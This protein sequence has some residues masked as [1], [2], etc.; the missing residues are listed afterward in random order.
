MRN[1][2]SSP[3]LKKSEFSTYDCDCE[4][5][6]HNSKEMELD[7]QDLVNSHKTKSTRSYLSQ[8]QI[9]TGPKELSQSTLN[10]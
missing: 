5:N 8:S 3:K 9:I 6:C 2:F 4:C 1:C 10:K 7:P